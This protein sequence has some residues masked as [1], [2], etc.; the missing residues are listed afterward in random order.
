[1]KF[2]FT[3]SSWGN[4]NYRRQEVIEIDISPEEWLEDYDGC[5]GDVEEQLREW[6]YHDLS[7]DFEIEPEDMAEMATLGARREEERK[8]IFDKPLTDATIE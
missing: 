6:I 1:M 3:C 7:F 8:E 4:I 2:K 5:S